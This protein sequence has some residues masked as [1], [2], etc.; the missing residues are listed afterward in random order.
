M[1]KMPKVPHGARSVVRLLPVLLPLLV[2]AVPAGADSLLR[3][4]SHNDAFQLMGEA[5]AAK[6][7]EVQL[8][9]AGDRA[10]RDEGEVSTILRLDRN[11]LYVVHHARKAYSEIP[12]P[13]DLRPLM[14]S[15]A[16]AEQMTTLMKLTVAA[17]PTGETQKINGWNARKVR[18]AIASAMGMKIDATLWLSKEVAAYRVANQLVADLESLQPGAAAWTEELQRLDGFP[19]LRESTVDALGAH[20]KTREELTAVETREPPAGLYDPPAGYRAEP[21]NPA[22]GAR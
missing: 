3:I 10:R 2:V 8:W 5:Q 4:K 11:R 21:F 6:D 1:P 12:L 17:T 14:P 13:V 9:V 18:F 22:E 15:P 19:V 7:T 20:F 16:A